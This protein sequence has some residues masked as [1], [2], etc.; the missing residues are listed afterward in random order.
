[1]KFF[2]SK[3]YTELTGFIFCFKISSLG[4]QV[5]WYQYLR[6]NNWN[7]QVRIASSAFSANDLRGEKIQS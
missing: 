2:E 7:K 4:L 3:L 5:L 1:M 6:A